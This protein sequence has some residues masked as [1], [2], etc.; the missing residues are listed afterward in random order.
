MIFF[1]ESNIPKGIYTDNE[2]PRFEKNVVPKNP[3]PKPE[4]K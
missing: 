4:E 1:F 2:K 3:Q